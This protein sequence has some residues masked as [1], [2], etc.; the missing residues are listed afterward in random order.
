MRIILFEVDNNTLLSIS[1]T[2]VSQRTV[3]LAESLSV[4]FFW[5]SFFVYSREVT[6]SVNS[7]CSKPTVNYDNWKLRM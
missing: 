6:E 7:R 3:G 1:P 5:A 2:L 4:P